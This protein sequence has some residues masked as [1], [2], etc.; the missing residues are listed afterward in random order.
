MPTRERLNFF[1]EGPSDQRFVERILVRLFRNRYVH[2]NISQYAGTA[3]S[4]IDRAMRTVRM[5]SED[6]ILLADI[7]S[8]PTVAS[9]VAALRRTYPSL[10]PSSVH[11]VVQEIESWYLAGVGRTQCKT[12]GLR[13]HLIARGTDRLVKEEIQKMMRPS[14]RLNPSQL[15]VAVCDCY[16]WN[17]ALERNAS[18]DSFART[19]LPWL[20]KRRSSRE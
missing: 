13:H 18:L 8:H 5:R 19:F 7:D 15:L 3:P 16:N 4:T 20:P 6:Y 17:L 11:V 10:D 1:V 14:C 2:V 9:K 12:L